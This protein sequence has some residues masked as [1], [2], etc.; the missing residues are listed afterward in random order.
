MY[1]PTINAVIYEKIRGEE[2]M[3][4]NKLTL[5]RESKPYSLVRSFGRSYICES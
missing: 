5:E 2:K 4:Q 1:L 3:K